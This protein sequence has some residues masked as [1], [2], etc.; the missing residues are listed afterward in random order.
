MK[1]YLIIAC[2]VLWRELCYLS[3]SSENTFDFVFLNQGL[4]DTPD[5]LR[6][7]LQKAVDAA[8]EQVIKKYEA[9]LIGYGLCS[10]G[11]E[12]IISRNT[13][14]V[15]P[16]GHDCITFFLGSKERYKEYF[17]NNPGT[18]WYTAGWIDDTVQPGKERYENALAEYTERYGEDNA[19]YLMEMESN[20]FKEYK[21]AAFIDYNFMDLERYKQYTKEC[22][23]YLKWKYDELKGDTS[24]L[25]QFLMG[26]NGWTEDK[27]LLVE[28][29]EQI[30]ATHDERIID[31]KRVSR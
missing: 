14:L 12:G 7:E 13:R 20:W 31:K 26:E 28:P 23:D 15:V 1:R 24:L 22:A 8:D 18:Y 27:F 19:E 5:R 10:N 30:F 21:N 11:I 9:I 16:R 6:T 29:G 2:H 17:D 3:S 4:H 25:E